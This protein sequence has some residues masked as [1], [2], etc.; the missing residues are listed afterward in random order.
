[1][2]LN[3]RV[4]EY[5]KVVVVGEVNKETMRWGNVFLTTNWKLYIDNH[6]DQH[7]AAMHRLGIT[8]QDVLISGYYHQHGFCFR[9]SPG[10]DRGEITNDE[11][12]MLI[13]AAKRVC[14]RELGR[15]WEAGR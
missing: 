6:Q 1:M 8:W 12:R 9:S 3:D 5:F 4:D 14:N 11:S 10:E 2:L 7:D 15:D 13:S